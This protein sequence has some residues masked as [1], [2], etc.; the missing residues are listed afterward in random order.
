MYFIYMIENL[1]NGKIYIGQTSNPETR[2][3][4][5]RKAD[6]SSPL[7]H[8]AIRKY[9][10]ENFDFVLLEKCD[11][12][13]LANV[14][15]VFWIRHLGSVSPDGYNLKEGGDGGGLDSL[16]TREKKRFS[17][18]GENNSFYGSQHS[19]ESKKRISDAKTG[20]SIVVSPEDRRRRSFQMIVLNRSRRGQALP[21]EQIEKIR[22]AS[23]GRKH[24]KETIQKM[25]EAR[26]N[27]WAE[28]KANKIE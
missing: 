26:R 11:S 15:E 7:I 5:H 21:S 23:T 28:K 6:L 1:V 20:V 2:W 4:K 16:E 19:E 13:E 9:G 22:L 24:S 3:K 8:R 18:L 27:W 17:K 12:L 25:K 10:R 14:R